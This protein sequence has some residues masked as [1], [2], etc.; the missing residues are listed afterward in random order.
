MKILVLL[1][2]VATIT[3][4]G[5]TF[6]NV[7]GAV[8]P[9][10]IA[11]RSGSGE[12]GGGETEA[13]GGAVRTVNDDNAKINNND[14]NN[15][16]SNDLSCIMEEDVSDDGSSYMV[17]SFRIRVDDVDDDDDD[18]SSKQNTNSD[19]NKKDDTSPKPI[20]HEFGICFESALSASTSTSSSSSTNSDATFEH[21][22]VA[23]IT[24]SHSK[25]R[26][27]ENNK[28]KETIVNVS[29]SSVGSTSSSSLSSLSPEE[30]DA[31]NGVST[32]D[33]DDDN[34]DYTSNTRRSEEEK[35]AAA[36]AGSPPPMA[37]SNVIVGKARYSS[38]YQ[39]NYGITVG[40]VLE[41]YDTILAELSTSEPSESLGT[42]FTM[43]S[44]IYW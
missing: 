31:V 43:L 34:D 26:K 15:A 13:E 37:S 33:D 16:N 35:A 18:V 36:A 7:E 8:A 29:E 39:S 38:P 9:V 3:I 32:D 41:E 1:L 14:N 11:G 17:C 25:L 21:C 20:F 4:R 10:T 5:V 40:T 27:E 28:K 24:S 22:V 19:L 23:E 2:F 6:V 30:K 42:L 12:E 44:C